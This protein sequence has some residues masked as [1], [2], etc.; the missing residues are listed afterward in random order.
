MSSAVATLVYAT[1]HRSMPLDSLAESEREIEHFRNGDITA[2]L[3]WATWFELAGLLHATTPFDEREALLLD[4]L[5]ALLDR[6]RFNGFQGYVCVLKVPKLPVGA[7]YLSPSRA[8]EGPYDFSV[9]RPG[10]VGGLL[11]A[12]RIRERMRYSWDVEFVLKVGGVY[13]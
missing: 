3:F 12:T 1:A 8:K 5:A 13:S 9:S 10:P 2:S 7:A 4:D 11:F 6:K